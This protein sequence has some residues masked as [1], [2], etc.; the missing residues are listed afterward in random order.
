MRG[1]RNDVL[2]DGVRP[3]ASCQIR[4]NR[5]RGRSDQGVSELRN[6]DG[7]AL[8]VEKVSPRRAELLFVRDRVSGIEEAVRFEKAVEIVV[9]DR[10]D[11]GAARHESSS[12]LEDAALTRDAL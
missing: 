1:M 3:H 7:R 12:M 2:D 9:N 10:P 5:Q 6:E 8:G 11:H 4:N